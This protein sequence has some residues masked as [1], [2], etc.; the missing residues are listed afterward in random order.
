MPIS[1]TRTGQCHIPVPLDGHP[2]DMYYTMDYY[3]W[4]MVEVVYIHIIILLYYYYISYLRDHYNIHYDRLVHMVYI[5]RKL[6]SIEVPV[7]R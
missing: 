1:V 5:D 2:I 3:Y 7:Q 6:A 4:H